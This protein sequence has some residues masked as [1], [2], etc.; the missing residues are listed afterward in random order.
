MVKFG[1]EIGTLYQIFTPCTPSPNTNGHLLDFWGGPI[2]CQDAEGFFTGAS[3]TPTFE[4]L[5]VK[6]GG[7]IGTLYQMLKNA[8]KKHPLQNRTNV[9][10]KGGGGQRPFEQ[11][12]K[13]LHFFERKAS[14]SLAHLW[15]L[16]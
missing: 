7:K 2:A 3:L 10:I 13:K 15:V 11:C 16:F 1:G 14:L 12:S 6:F 5:M 9:Q 8:F 4:A